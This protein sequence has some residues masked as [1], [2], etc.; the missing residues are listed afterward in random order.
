M[1]AGALVP[2][3]I[4]GGVVAGGLAV[5]AS[6]Y[7]GVAGLQMQGE[8]LQSAME[9]LN[10]LPDRER[11]TQVTILDALSKAVEDPTRVQDTGDSDGDGDTK[12]M[13]PAFQV[14]VL[15]RINGLSDW[16]VRSVRP[17]VERF[18]TRDLARFEAALPQHQALLARAEIE[19]VDGPLVELLRALAR[20]TTFWGDGVGFWT[21]AQPTQAELDAFSCASDAASCNEDL[22]RPAGYDEVDIVN[23]DLRGLQRLIGDIQGQKISTLT[24]HWETWVPLFERAGLARLAN[25]DA[26]G[27]FQG[28][29]AWVAGIQAMRDRL[30]ACAFDVS[31]LVLNPPCQELR[32]GA[33]A[34][35]TI[36]QDLDDEFVPVLGALQA[37]ADDAERLW[38]EARSAKRRLKGSGA[39]LSSGGGG[40]PAYYQWRDSAG[41]HRVEVQVSDFILPYIDV[42]EHGSALSKETCVILKDH[43][44]ETGANTWVT[45]KRVEPR[46]GPTGLWTWN[47][48][49]SEIKK[50]A[51][52]SYSPKHVKIV[53]TQ[54]CGGI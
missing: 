38:D 23:D 13:V 12:E 46:N 33:P 3:E 11:I 41:Q 26:D 9:Q 53:R 39:A 18:V 4:I 48:G 5:G 47:P 2:A 50:A 37:L 27:D 25:G 28:V 32:L 7:N 36:D 52:V 40:N 51:C 19:G 8:A 6:I 35:A 20:D 42:E 34:F 17:S 1:F 22:P 45:V 43:T 21:A 49:Q 16:V 54:G 15:N 24:A 29:R 10:G 44:D 31:G 30:P 14:W